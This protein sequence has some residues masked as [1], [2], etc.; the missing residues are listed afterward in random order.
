MEEATSTD[1][2][3]DDL[4]STDTESEAEGPGR[5]SHTALGYAKFKN[6]VG[7]G[8]QQ[9]EGPKQDFAEWAGAKTYEE[10][11]GRNIR[12]NNGGRWSPKAATKRW[13]DNVVEPLRLCRYAPKH[14]VDIYV[15]DQG[16]PDNIVS[17]LLQAAR[18]LAANQDPEFHSSLVVFPSFTGFVHPHYEC[19]VE[20]SDGF[21][22]G[23]NQGIPLDQRMQ[24]QAIPFESA[25][26]NAYSATEGISLTPIQ[27]MAPYASVLLLRYTDLSKIPQSMRQRILNRNESTEENLD[28]LEKMRL[29]DDSLVKNY[30]PDSDDDSISV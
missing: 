16:N 3:K 23:V 27:A 22:G 4:S 24:V 13:I 8:A 30:Y 12:R 11:R 6:H 10:W 28:G 18:A 29:M 2:S 26:V 15:M 25:L 20:K 19:F 5:S 17:H 21:V 9:G 1:C 7:G 14:E